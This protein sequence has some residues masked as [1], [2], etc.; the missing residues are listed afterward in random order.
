MIVNGA[1][2][3]AVTLL[4]F[5]TLALELKEN[6]KVQLVQIKLLVQEVQFPGHAVQ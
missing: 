4:P 5:E 3:M 6:P 1:L 2:L